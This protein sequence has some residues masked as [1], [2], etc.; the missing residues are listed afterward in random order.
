MNKVLYVCNRYAKGPSSVCSQPSLYTTTRNFRAQGNSPGYIYKA[1]NKVITATP[2]PTTG[3]QLS[4]TT[5]M[6]GSK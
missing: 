6:T 4:Q 5:H 3:Q 2:T 1:A